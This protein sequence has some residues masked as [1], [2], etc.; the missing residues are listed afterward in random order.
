LIPTGGTREY[1]SMAE[2]TFLTTWA[3][4]AP[5]EAVWD[6]IFDSERWPEWWKGVEK[7]VEIEPGDENGVGSLQRYTWKSRLPYRLEF[8][9]RTTRV[10]RPHLIEGEAEGDL[11]GSGRWRLF[12]GRGTAV[13]YEWSVR[14]TEPWMNVIAPIARPV[15][16]WNHDVVMRQGGEGLARRLGAP[17]LVPTRRDTG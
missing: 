9:M 3:V 14:T 1:R 8:D 15:F 17:L 2:Y 4:D 13:T 10:E 6:A 11:D 5:I 12:D 16:A 7:V